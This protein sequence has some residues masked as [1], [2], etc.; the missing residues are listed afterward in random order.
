MLMEIVLDGLLA[1]PIPSYI[2]D[3][4]ALVC[5]QS[6]IFSKELAVCISAALKRKIK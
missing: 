3:Q 5:L 1:R 6:R 4:N 2:R